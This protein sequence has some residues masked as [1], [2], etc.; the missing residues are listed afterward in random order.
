MVIGV[1]VDRD[2]AVGSRSEGDGLQSG[3]HTVIAGYRGSHDQPVFAYNLMSPISSLQ[4]TRRT[5][6]L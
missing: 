1:I 5:E 2:R 6:L 4:A 3:G